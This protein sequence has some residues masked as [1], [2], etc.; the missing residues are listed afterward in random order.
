[1]AGAGFGG[2]AGVGDAECAGFEDFG[3]EVGCEGSGGACVCQE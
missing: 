1:M 3:A 2:D